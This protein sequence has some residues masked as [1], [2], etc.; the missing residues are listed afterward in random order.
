MFSAML[1][2]GFLV[3]MK[4]IH[5]DDFLAFSFS[6][7]FVINHITKP[8]RTQVLPPALAIHRAFTIKSLWTRLV[9]HIPGSV[10]AGLVLGARSSYILQQALAN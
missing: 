4:V 7:E 5:S 10:G 8:L 1:I 3:S 6:W 2:S 9:Y